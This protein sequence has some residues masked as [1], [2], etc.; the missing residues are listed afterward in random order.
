MAAGVK[1]C[2]IRTTRKADSLGVSWL[3]GVRAI[4]IDLLMDS[5]AAEKASMVS[6]NRI[7]PRRP[8]VLGMLVILAMAAIIAWQAMMARSREVAMAERE[9]R[10]AQMLQIVQQMAVNVDKR[11]QTLHLM[12]DL[13]FERDRE[14][15]ASR[16][17]HAAVLDA[18]TSQ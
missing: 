15:R 5:D 16:T 11:E 6:W 7:D 3:H 12:H 8:L 17:S 10:V 1:V 13:V 2:S 4:A 14:Y 9:R 18:P